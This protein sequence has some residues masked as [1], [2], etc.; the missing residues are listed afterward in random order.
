MLGLFVLQR[1]EVNHT[2]DK[3]EAIE[4]M[5]DYIYEHVSE[6][7]LFLQLA[8]EAAELSHAAMKMVRFINGDCPSGLT[9]EG[10]SNHIAEE[11]GD[12]MNCIDVITKGSY[13]PASEVLDSGE[14]K[15]I[16]YV[17]HNK[18]KKQD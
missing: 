12:V 8:E 11:M 3:N 5:I 9:K 18:K 6:P 7:A 16:R 1:K 10:I 15:M 13:I 4:T 14:K 2:N 17:N